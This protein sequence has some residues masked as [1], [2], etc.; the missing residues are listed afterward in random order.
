[1]SISILIK[2]SYLYLNKGLAFANPFLCSNLY[3]IHTIQ[4]IY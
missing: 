3:V 2:I 4:L 1:M